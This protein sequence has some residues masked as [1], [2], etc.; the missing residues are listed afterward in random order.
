LAAGFSRAR[1]E[2]PVLGG[3]AM[4]SIVREL[5]TFLLVRK[6]YWLFPVI[7]ALALLGGVVVLGK[8]SAVMPLIYTIF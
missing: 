1:D 4:F 5:F 8:G 7:G 3:T 6:K 2:G